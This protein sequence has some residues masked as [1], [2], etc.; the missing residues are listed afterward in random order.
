MMTDKELQEMGFTREEWNQMI[1][2][3]TQYIEDWAKTIN[4]NNL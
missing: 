4:P 2:E 1:E 3:E